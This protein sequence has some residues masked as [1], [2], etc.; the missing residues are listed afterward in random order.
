MH[1][2]NK[3][4]SAFY[5]RRI[6]NSFLKIILPIFFFISCLFF[7]AIDV[8]HAS[9]VAD[10]LCEIG[11][12]YYKKGDYADALHELNKALILEPNHKTAQK[13]I[14]IIQDKLGTEKIPPFS[15]QR[16]SL[17]KEERDAVIF[18]ALEEFDEVLI[19]KEGL[20][21]PAGPSVSP[22]LVVSPKDKYD[23][24]GQALDEPGEVVVIREEPGVR[25][26]PSKPALVL[27]PQDK[28]DIVRKSLDKF[29][30]KYGLMDISDKARPL[31]TD[32]VE[33]QIEVQIPTKKTAEAEEKVLDVTAPKQIGT[34]KVYVKQL[35]LDDTVRTTQPNTELNLQI[36]RDLIITG[37]N[38]ARFLVVDPQKLEIERLRP[39]EILLKA[40]KIGNT[41]LHLW[42][43]E[44]RWTFIAQ[45]SPFR[46]GAPT[47][48]ELLRQKIE[49]AGAFKLFYSNDWFSF[50]SGR[51]TDSLEKQSL[52]FYQSLGLE[53][54][55]PYG[56]FDS[57]VQF[58]K[59]QDETD[60]TY[61]TLGLEDGVLGPFKGF[62]VRAFDYYVDFGNLAFGGAGLRGAKL[63]SE[64][65]ND[66]VN[67]TVFW[68]RENEGIFSPL[69]PG[70]A[71]SKDS[72]IEGA[73][74]GITFPENFYQ[75]FS[76]FH[77]YGSAR[78]SSLKPDAYDYTTE[79]N[80]GDFKLR[81]DVS[82][83]GDSTAYLLQSIYNVSKLQLTGEFR[84]IQEKFY[85]IT[86]R[87]Y[88]SGELG[89]LLSYRYDPSTKLSL[90]GR[91]DVYRD[92]LFPNPEHPNR[93]N[94][95]V[96][97]ELQYRFNQ[98]T[99]MRLDYYGSN[100]RGTVSP[101]K[102]ENIGISL[103]KTVD[104]IKKLNFYLGA[105]HQRSEN[106]SSP[107]LDYTNK[108]LNAGLRFGITDN[109]YYFVS[110]EFN[111]L[112]EYTG[113][114]SKPHVWE[115]GL[116][117]N[118]QISDSPFYLNLRFFYRDEE[119]ATSSRSFLSGEDNFEAQ[120]EL[121]YQPTENFNAFV[122]LRA[123]NIWA[124]NP[125]TTKRLEAEVRF[126]ARWAFDTGFKW[127]PVGSITGIV[128]KDLNSDGMYQSDEPLMENIRIV[129][130]RD[131]YDTTD[132]EGKYLF[133]NIRARKAFIYVDSDTLPAG[134]VLIGPSS[135][136]ITIKNGALIHQDFGIVARSEIYGIIFND[137]NGN[138]KFDRGE[139][140]IDEV[141]LTLEDGTKTETND[142][143]QYYLRRV[144]P[145]THTLTLNIDSLPVNLIP[146]VPL[147]KQIELFE[148]VT[149]IHNIPLK[150]VKK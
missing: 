2:T 59:L 92:R 14:R 84:N 6:F 49:E 28:S 123:N 113:D 19:T 115:T 47:L 131:K 135:K 99:S 8:I 149:Y 91:F 48:A 7:S 58:N 103:Y 18:K 107:T 85:G 80:L 150:E 136:E 78:N 134:F 54:Q 1:R 97:S 42:D 37:R 53:G 140:G 63:H 87:P 67:Y 52:S 55:T 32:V 72:F 114:L 94:V 118:R 61:Y 145:G 64:A 4:Y 56:D 20:E 46:S 112:E 141:I 36:G 79:T 121:R 93:Y 106:L 142:N 126:G 44:G 24:V 132:S 127:N 124:E 83:D 30:A 146:Q 111:W 11:I 139:D 76:F 27:V 66:K 90:S 108:K 13:Y 75:T 119:D 102:D 60:I 3:S 70:L 34:K 5:K 51:R 35:S 77:G 117:Y 43:D 62:D 12:E 21:T 23:V 71:E 138:G 68:G 144:E 128:F 33:M 45:I 100:N 96:N 69:S 65:F 25:R 39:D 122:N 143:G 98:D 129:L 104:F 110:K 148:G 17:T 9:D 82:S 73:R 50:Y 86:G 95:N 40:K 38:I 89:G 10:F 81:T 29:E 130:G 105:R 147:F 41:Y 22:P 133:K 116:N 57:R 31:L 101:R 120:S 125:D 137:S 88:A 16:P 109:L 26:Q 74:L 15:L